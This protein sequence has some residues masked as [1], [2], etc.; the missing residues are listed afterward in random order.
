MTTDSPCAAASAAV[1]DSL[2]TSL[3]SIIDQ[4]SHSLHEPF[5]N[6]HMATPATCRHV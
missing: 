5:L 2:E 6:Q 3:P 1:V 4:L